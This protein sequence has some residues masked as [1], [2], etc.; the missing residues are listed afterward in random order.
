MVGSAPRGSVSTTSSAKSP[1]PYGPRDRLEDRREDGGD[2]RDQAEV[3]DLVRRIDLLDLEREQDAGD[4]DA[5]RVHGG[6]AEERQ[7]EQAAAGR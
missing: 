4:P 2:P 3:G 7:G 1:A 6:V 5:E